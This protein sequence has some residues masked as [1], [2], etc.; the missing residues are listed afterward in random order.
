MQRQWEQSNKDYLN[1]KVVCENCGAAT[2]RC[3]TF[4]HK[5][6]NNCRTV[7]NQKQLDAQVDET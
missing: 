7:T 2:N 6:S 1:E 5:H 4:R 3:N